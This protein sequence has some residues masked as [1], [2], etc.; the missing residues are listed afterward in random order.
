MAGWRCSRS[1][2]QWGIQRADGPWRPAVPQGDPVFL[3][4]AR[5]MWQQS[6]LAWRGPGR[7]NGLRKRQAAR[8]TMRKWCDYQQGCSVRG[9]ESL[10]YEMLIPTVASGAFPEIH[11]GDGQQIA[12][13]DDT[14]KLTSQYIPYSASRS[15]IFEVS[16]PSY[17]SFFRRII[18][19][20][21][22]SLRK[23]V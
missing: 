23:Y 11:A 1:E 21:V 6:S 19:L 7:S 22:D 14:A 9:G 3:E 4:K 8:G 17:S 5:G 10:G 12:L 2:G 15:W 13:A 16:S 20:V 18:C